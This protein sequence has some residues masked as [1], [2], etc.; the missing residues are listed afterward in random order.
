[1]P[2]RLEYKYLVSN[3]LLDAIRADMR[4]FVE[5]DPFAAQ[6]A[7]NAY[8]VRSIYYDT[9]SFSCYHEKHAG[10]Q[11]RMKFR[12]RGY[13]TPD[14]D[15]VVFLEIKRKYNNFIDKNRAPLLSTE[16]DT[17]FETR[18]LDKHILSFSGNGKEKS[19]AQRFLYHYYRYGLRPAVLVIYDR[20]PFI[21]K[22]DS[23]L[24]FTFDKNLRSTLFPSLDM[25]YEEK[26]IKYAMPNYFIFEVKFFTGLPRWIPSIIKRYA[27][28]RMAL[29]K[30]TICLDSHKSPRK[31]A[32]GL[33]VSR[34][35]F[36]KPALANPKYTTPTRYD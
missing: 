35:S 2:G 22:F 7:S 6:K 27:L 5:L 25:L 36:S 8:T 12:I 9:P 23:R 29:S 3:T 24:R 26:Q 19:D 13:D 33:A 4:P 17:L 11:A 31:F 18:D 21:G 10:V 15:S 20:E 16:L 32:Q 14:K 28:P 34:A 1:M 30:Y